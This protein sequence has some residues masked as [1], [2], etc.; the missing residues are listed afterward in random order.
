MNDWDDIRYFLAMVRTGSTT[1]A[2]RRLA[3]NHS[4]VSRRI[5]QLE[6]RIGVRLFD[7]LANGLVPTAAGAELIQAAE[8]VERNVS[9]FARQGSARDARLG[10]KLT[11]TVPPLLAQYVLMP[12]I[13]NCCARYPDL[14][15]VMRAT[16]QISSLHQREADV[17]IRAT[18]TPQDT[19]IG[20][21][22]AANENALFCA[23]S[24]LKDRKLTPEAAAR[25]AHLEWIW[26]D[27]GQGRPS[28]ASTYFAESEPSITVDTKLG[29]AVAA[30][31]G[32][33]VSELPV[34]VG[35]SIAG[36]IRLPNLAVKS[37]K[38]V[39]VLYHRDFRHT[40]RVRAF[41]SDI[42]KQFAA[43]VST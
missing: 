28:W 20:H 4:T 15:I 5:A 41:V 26:H 35:S 21:R 23:A 22:L 31:S 19:L 34:M 24:F 16:D 40:A 37:D 32:F 10:G 13:A 18:A 2:A 6:A 29:A 9:R 30:Q 39:W 33:G 27:A 7:R 36:L 17:A 12:M 42:R 3:V 8:Q 14:D 38:D 11:V 25:C 1:A 43:L